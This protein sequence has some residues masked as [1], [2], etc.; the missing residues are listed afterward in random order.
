MKLEELKTIEQLTQFLEGNQAVLFSLNS[1]KIEHYKWFQRELIRFKYGSLG[2]AKKGVL[3][4]YLIKV[5]GYSQSQITR[6][7]K[8]YRETGKITYR[9]V[10][11]KGFKGKYTKEDIRLLAHMDERHSMPCGHTVKK[12][13]ERA[14]TVFNEKK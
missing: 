3:A 10:A 8:Q 13:C 11:S 12:L 1:S 4:R 9:H 5:S 7:I 2:K 6:L 14:Y